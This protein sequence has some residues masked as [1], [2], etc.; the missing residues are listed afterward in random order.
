VFTKAP[1]ARPNRTAG[2]DRSEEPASWDR[3]GLLL[4]G[5]RVGGPANVSISPM[6]VA[7]VVMVIV[8]VVMVIAIVVM[9]IVMM[10]TVTIVISRLM[11]MEAILVLRRSC[12]RAAHAEDRHRECECR[13][14]AKD[15][16]EGLFHGSFPFF[17][18]SVLSFAEPA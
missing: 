11:L 4:R 16:E 12:I 15:G 1:V 5:Y 18:G 9:V 2:K 8:M 7:K 10:V 3:G 14:E 13:C 17:A 6:V